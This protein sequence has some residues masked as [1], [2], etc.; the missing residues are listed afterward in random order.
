MSVS[1]RRIRRPTL[2]AAIGLAATA[3]LCWTALTVTSDVRPLTN[4][5]L[6]AAVGM[7]YAPSQYC[8]PLPG[9]NGYPEPSCD[10]QCS[11]CE[12]WIAEG[13][14][15]AQGGYYGS[16]MELPDHDCGTTWQGVCD[17]VCGYCDMTNKQN[18]GSC[19]L[20]PQC[21]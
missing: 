10:T 4:A 6:E 3:A 15:C 20:V 2:L 14:E 21:Q 19:G 12:N 9:C 13:G 18:M 8:S 11:Y 5:E 1:K 17:Y 16:C 7:Q